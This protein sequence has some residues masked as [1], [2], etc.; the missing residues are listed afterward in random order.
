MKL[1]RRIISLLIVVII[2]S[3]L[4]VANCSV[5]FGHDAILDVDYDDCRGDDRED[6]NSFHI[7][8]LLS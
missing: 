3:N 6:S 7:I 5:V 4:L 2:V 8:L 1:D